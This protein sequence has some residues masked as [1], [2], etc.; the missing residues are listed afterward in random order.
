MFF[1]TAFRALEQSGSAPRWTETESDAPPAEQ[2]SDHPRTIEPPDRAQPVTDE[3]L[4][5]MSKALAKRLNGLV[6]AL[7]R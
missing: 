5:E 6:D 2:P 3:L 1:S 4:A 7:R